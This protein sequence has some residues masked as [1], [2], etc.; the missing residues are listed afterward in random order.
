MGCIQGIDSGRTRC[1]RARHDDEFKVFLLKDQLTP[2]EAICLLGLTQ[3]MRYGECDKA[4]VP[5]GTSIVEYMHRKGIF[6]ACEDAAAPR[7]L[8]PSSATSQTR[9]VAP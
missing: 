1:E 2:D 8:C 9:T 6:L 5:V 7:A 3:G 4:M